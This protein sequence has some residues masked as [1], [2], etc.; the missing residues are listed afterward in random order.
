LLFEETCFSCRR[1]QGHKAT[2]KCGV[3]Q[4]LLCKKCAFFLASSTFSFREKIADEL[5]HDYYCYFCHQQHVEP[6]RESYLK[7][8]DRARELYFFFN[9]QKR[10]IPVIRR[11]KQKVQVQE[12]QD[13]D[14]TI[15]RLAFF[16]A[17]LGYNSVIEAQVNSKKVRN[18]GYQT[19]VWSGVGLP[20][21][22]DAAKLECSFK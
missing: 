8:V 18:A 16:A 11:G 12:C 3:C 6:A 9:T 2:V 20:A 14:E 13:R 10:S 5:K 21:E 17:E 22:V 19:S 1:T 4:V 7:L 15:L